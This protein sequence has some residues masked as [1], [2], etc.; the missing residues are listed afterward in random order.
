M[1]ERFFPEDKRLHAMLF[2]LL[3]PGK[4]PDCLNLTG[5]AGPVRS[6]QTE[7]VLH[8]PM[9][10]LFSFYHSTVDLFLIG[11]VASPLHSL[12]R[13]FGKNSSWIVFLEEET[14]VRMTKL[15]QVLAKFDKNKVSLKYSL[16]I[17][18]SVC[19]SPFFSLS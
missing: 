19:L 5:S 13:S 3:P 7:R 10:R 11:A 2:V 15:V 6:D 16:R 14:N 9:F 18:L 1:P 4:S 12:S 8:V 17:P